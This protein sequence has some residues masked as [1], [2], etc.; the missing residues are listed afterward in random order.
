[1]FKK[2]AELAKA[3]GFDEVEIHSAREKAQPVCQGGSLESLHYPH[4]HH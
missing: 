2:I 1:M 4:Q 3:V